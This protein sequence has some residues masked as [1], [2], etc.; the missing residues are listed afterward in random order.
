MRNGLIVLGI[1]IA[2]IGIAGFAGLI[3]FSQMKDVV[4]IGEFSAAVERKERPP[5]WINATLVGAGALLAGY[6]LARRR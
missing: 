6:G 1:V 3:E 2:A 4:E 5:L